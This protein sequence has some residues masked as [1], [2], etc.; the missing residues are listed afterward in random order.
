MPI[1]NMATPIGRRPSLP[2]S[3][4]ENRAPAICKG[5]G[6]TAIATK[7]SSDPVEEREHRSSDMWASPS[8][9]TASRMPA[10][11]RAD[12]FEPR[13]ECALPEREDDDGREPG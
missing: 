8:H 9:S 12:S 1:A 13:G 10:A 11:K 2:L 7:S 6:R 5:E 4:S 3:S